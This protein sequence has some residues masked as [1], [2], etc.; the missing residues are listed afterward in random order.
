MPPLKKKRKKMT[1]TT[2]N[3]KKK[4]HKV[5]K[6]DMTILMGDFNAKIGNNKST[7]NIGTFGETTCNSNGVKQ[8]FSPL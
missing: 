8:R 3:Y 1:N 4:N 2:S 5:N 7:G 6:S